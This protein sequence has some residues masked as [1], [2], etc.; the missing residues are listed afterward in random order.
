MF[1]TAFLLRSSEY[2][3][4]GPDEFDPCNMQDTAS[5]LLSTVKDRRA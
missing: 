1:R 3:Y 5:L 4:V 2:R